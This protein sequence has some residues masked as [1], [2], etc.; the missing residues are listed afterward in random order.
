MNIERTKYAFP[1]R[2]KLTE[3]V[4]ESKAEEILLQADKQYK[5]LCYENSSDSEALKI[6]TEKSIYPV[7]ALYQ[8]LLQHFD[9]A[10]SIRLTEILFRESVFMQAKTLQNFVRT[11]GIES[12]FPQIFAEEMQKNYSVESGFIID[13]ITVSPEKARFNVRSCPYV[14]VLTRFNC[15]EICYL[16]CMADELCY[17]NISESLHWN[18]TNTLANQNKCCDFSLEYYES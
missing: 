9:K 1:W 15:P 16:F 8:V 13:W 6:H 12:S 14:M 10:E 4:G 5:K 7:V 3:L 18:R 17:N 2:K 11:M